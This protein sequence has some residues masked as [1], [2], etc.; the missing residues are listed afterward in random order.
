FCRHG[1]QICRPWPG[2]ISL[3][4]SGPV[5][6]NWRFHLSW[7]LE[8]VVQFQLPLVQLVATLC[9]PRPQMYRVL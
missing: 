4:G 7:N 5:V 2:C 3:S 6:V 1:P 9:C 8:F